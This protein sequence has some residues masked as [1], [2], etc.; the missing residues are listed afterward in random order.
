LALEFIKKGNVLKALSIREFRI[1]WIGQVVSQVG[2]GLATLAFIILIDRYTNSS[3]LAIS[4]ITIALALPNLIFGLFSGVYVDRW[5]R[6]TVLIV[7]DAIR[8]LLML[9]P[10][11][12]HDS[13]HIWI[14]Y[15]VAFLQSAIGTFFEPA[16]NAII[17]LIVDQEHLM[18]ANAFSQTTKLLA[19]VLGTALAGVLVGLAGSGWPAFI[20]N[21][22][23]FFISVVFCSLLRIPKTRSTLQAAGMR[24]VFQQLAEG[25]SFVGKSR[26]LLTVVITNTF[27]MLGLGSVIVLIIP[28]L[29]KDLG[30]DTTWIGIIQSLEV[31]GMILGAVLV[32]SLAS[33][34]R[35][36]W[37]M[38]AGVIGMGTFIALGEHTYQLS[39]L[40]YI[41]L[42]VGLC[43][44]A[45]QAA[46]ATLM[47]KL[48][49]NEKRGR[50]TSA[51]TTVNSIANIVSMAFAGVLGAVLGIRYVFFIAG[52]II[53][54]AGII[55][56]YLMAG[57]PNPIPVR[58]VKLKPPGG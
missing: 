23:S 52:L 34:V 54:I 3:P 33:R 28:F 45:A 50:A 48:V 8:G 4:G 56:I 51:M 16:K 36:Q 41:I 18:G 30:V 5:N 26:T 44:T 32:T 7:S 49:P 20:L 55:G 25:M 29:T 17:P 10:L 15:V 19:Q 58:D 12:V 6:K 2:D 47:Q 35:T 14:F 31:V 38:M 21:S 27:T 57:E 43:L 46:A 42:G 1:L 37:I 24:S 13:S 53:V 9:I 40:I 11:L 22:V 39:V